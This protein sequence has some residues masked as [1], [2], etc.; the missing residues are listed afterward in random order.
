MRQ[1]FFHEYMYNLS[2]A[3]AFLTMPEDQKTHLKW[4]YL[5]EQCKVVF[6]VPCNK[7]NSH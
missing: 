1:I 4:Q 6:K 2:Q 7:G 5:L 3:Q